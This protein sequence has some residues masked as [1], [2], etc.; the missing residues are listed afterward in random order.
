MPGCWLNVALPG[1][2]TLV[3]VADPAGTASVTFA[4]PDAP[5]FTGDVFSQ[6]FH[7]DFAATQPS[8]AHRRVRHQVR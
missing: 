3:A 4:Q 2:D 7:L 6:W 8:L 1:F 5:L